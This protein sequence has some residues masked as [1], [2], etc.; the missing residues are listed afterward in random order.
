MGMS[1]YDKLLREYEE[2]LDEKKGIAALGVAAGLG[3]AAG[4]AYQSNAQT[5]NAAAQSPESDTMPIWG[6]GDWGAGAEEE[7]TSSRSAPPTQ[8]AERPLGLQG[9]YL[10]LTMWAEARSEG[11]A[12][13][14]AVGHVIMNRVRNDRW[15][16]SVQGVVKAD[17]QFSCWNAR[18]PNLKKMQEMWQLDQ[19]I[20]KLEPYS[21]EW[22][23]AIE[24]MQ[25]D[26]THAEWLKYQEAKKLAARI[27]AGQGRDP[28]GG[29][30]F[31][32]TTGVDPVW[33]RGQ[34]V[35]AK[36]G[37]HLFYRTDAKA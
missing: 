1:E 27:V 36:I 32:H 11:R 3:I 4:A 37:S 6:A 16:D 29:S 19:R 17:R 33:N 23:N 21:D 14:N 24:E 13:M 35:V 15:G 34:Q 31:Y 9:T 25:A 12:G 2:Y 18:D 20:A 7:P 8:T 30:L 10:A 5:D 22:N 26:G 28:T